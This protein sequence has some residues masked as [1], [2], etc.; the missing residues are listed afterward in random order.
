MNKL[1][2]VSIIIPTYNRAA[3]IAETLDSIIRQTY[4]NWECII[5]DDGS[6][7]DTEALVGKYQLRDKRIKYANR[8][9]TL[10]KGA[11]ACRNYGLSLSEGEYVNWFDS[12][13]L[14]LPKKLELQ[15]DMLKSSDLPFVVCQT[16]VFEGPRKYTRLK[17]K[18][19]LF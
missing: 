5:V 11:N 16:L 4:D 15:V 17:K 7:D 3:L 12:D 19:Y 9:S 13:D 2:L 6:S 8:P 10:K 14:M 1:G 18:R